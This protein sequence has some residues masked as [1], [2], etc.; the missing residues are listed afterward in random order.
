LNQPKQRLG[1]RIV[2][3]GQDTTQ[4]LLGRGR[5]VSREGGDSSAQTSIGSALGGQQ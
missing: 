3:Q 2:L 4:R 1:Q 5:V